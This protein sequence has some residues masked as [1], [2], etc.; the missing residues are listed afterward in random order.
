[1]RAAVVLSA[2]ALLAAAGLA[3]CAKTPT[4]VLVVVEADATVPPLLILR[5]TLARA[6]DPGARVSSTLRSL[7]ENSDA[8][9]RPGPFFFPLLL[10]L[11][12]DPSFAGA[13]TITIEGLD[14][15]SQAVLASGTTLAEVAAD[16]QT[17]AAV[18]L[19]AVPAAGSGDGGSGDAASDGGA[20]SVD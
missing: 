20:G 7:N 10:P 4:Q 1:V 6:A 18:T 8:A 19:T 9:N 2:G 14:W 13:V 11:G 15:D 17:N 12:L 3:G 16:R 5:S